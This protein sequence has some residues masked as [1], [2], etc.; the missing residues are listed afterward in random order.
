MASSSG[1]STMPNNYEEA[2]NFVV[3]QKNVIC[4]CDEH[5]KV[6]L[7]RTENNNGR[8][9]WRC[10]RWSNQCD[11]FYWYDEWL[12][13]RSL[14]MLNEL[15]WLNANLG[16]LQSIDLNANLEDTTMGFAIQ[17]VHELRSEVVEL[18]L[19]LTK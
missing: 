16:A 2:T 15:C 12:S 7:A 17:E 14:L 13:D 6:F 4:D 18:R 8:R 3:K 9:F 1:V 11:S 5:V 19:I 10:A